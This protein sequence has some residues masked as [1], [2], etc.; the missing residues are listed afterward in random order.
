MAEI[1]QSASRGVRE[2]DQRRMAVNR[3]KWDESVALHVASPSYD[4]PAFIGGRST[5]RT[6][7]VEGLAPVRN[8]SLLHLQCHFGMDTLSWARR[9]AR[10]TGVDFSGPAVEAARGLAA[11]TGLDAR[12]VQS[13]IYELPRKLRGEFDLVYTGKG[14]LC[15]LPDLAKWA[16]IVARYLKPGGRLFFLED[17]PAADVYRNEDDADHFQFEFPYFATEPQRDEYPGTYAATTAKMRNRVSYGWAHP[18]SEVLNSL[19]DAGLEIGRIGE[20]PYSYWHKF[21]F[22]RKDAEGWWRLTR[23]Q[24]MVPL[25]WSISA[26]KPPLRRLSR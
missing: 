7:E 11:Q 1:S 12:F 17:H 26:S 16:R 8:R 10:V 23:D 24:D 22:M 3:R 5:L 20:Y 15:W 9:G 18:V 19:S 21:P 25:M 14:A 4:V 2:I 13:N 6:I